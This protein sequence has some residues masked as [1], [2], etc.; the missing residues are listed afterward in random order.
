MDK[1]DH[2][3]PAFGHATD[4]PDMHVHWHGLSK[5]EYML[6]SVTSAL[7]ASSTDI[8]PKAAVEVAK[9]VV[10]ELVIQLRK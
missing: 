5:Y 3:E 7:M 6:T 10:D 4:G 1:F 9:V 2:N 8:N